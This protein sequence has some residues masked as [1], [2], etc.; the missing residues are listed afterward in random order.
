M[1][2]KR[3]KLALYVAICYTTPSLI[4]GVFLAAIELAFNF[5]GGVFSPALFLTVL[6]SIFIY[7]FICMAVSVYLLEGLE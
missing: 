7:L 3:L 5:T 1:K 2:I 6:A 4:A